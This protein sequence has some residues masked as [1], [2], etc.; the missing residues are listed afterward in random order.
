MKAPLIFFAFLGL[1]SS[2]QSQ[3]VGDSK[4]SVGGGGYFVRIPTDAQMKAI[5][6]QKEIPTGMTSKMVWVLPGKVVARHKQHGETILE[7]TYTKKTDD[8]EESTT[9][10]VADH[11]DAPYLAVDERAKCIVVPGPIRDDFQGRRLYY[12]FD[13]NEVSE[14]NLIRFKARYADAELE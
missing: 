12:F 5:K 7:I 2:V 11:P 8:G 10:L 9:L 3:L 1:C 13:K 14:K 4:Q 6:E